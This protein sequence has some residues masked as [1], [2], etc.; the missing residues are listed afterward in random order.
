MNLGMTGA[1]AFAY[2]YLS[3]LAA[4]T[5]AHGK[6][7]PRQIILSN[8]SVNFG[9]FYWELRAETAEPRA[10]WD[11]LEEVFAEA[12]DHHHAD[13]EGHIT[14]TFLPYELNRLMFDRMNALAMRKSVRRTIHIWNRLSR[15]DLSPIDQTAYRTECLGRIRAILADGRASPLLREDPNGASAF[16]QLRV[17]RRS[18]RRMRRRGSPVKQR[19]LEASNGLS[20]EP[21]CARDDVAGVLS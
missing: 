14:D 13:L 1:R 15:W 10:S 11:R 16:M 20:P 3:H 2:G 5:V 17:Y 12:H 19:M 4:D 6:Y 21:L 8:C 18:W 7:V 9:H